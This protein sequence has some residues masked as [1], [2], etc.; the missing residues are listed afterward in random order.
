MSHSVVV[1]VDLD[2]FE[3][4]ELLE[5]LSFRKDMGKNK[6]PLANLDIGGVVSLLEAIKC[7]EHIIEQL[8]EWAR[9]PL[10]DETKLEKWVAMCGVSN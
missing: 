9:Q 4:S 1:E 5:E 7:P 10:A 2:D 6:I 3:T 8:S